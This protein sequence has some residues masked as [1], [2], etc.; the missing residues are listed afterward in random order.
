MARALLDLI[1]QLLSFIIDVAQNNPEM[2]WL[3]VLAVG[4]GTLK[5]A[6]AMID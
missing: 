5:I 2:T 6:I 1:D 4:A 3:T